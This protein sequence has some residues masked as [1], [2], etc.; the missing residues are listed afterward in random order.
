MYT[1]EEVEV[2]YIL[3][4]LYAELQQQPST[5]IQN[6]L[7]NSVLEFIWKIANHGIWYTTDAY[8]RKLQPFEVPQA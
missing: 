1:R 8:Q 6:V 5:D 3:N 4:S 7:A 2:E